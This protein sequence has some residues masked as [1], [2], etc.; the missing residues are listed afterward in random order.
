MDTDGDVI[1]VTSQDDLAECN[2]DLNNR[3]VLCNSVEAAR[4]ILMKA[5]NAASEALN[6]SQSLNQSFASINDAGAQSARGYGQLGAVGMGAYPQTELL[7][8]LHCQMPMY[9][10]YLTQRFHNVPLSGRFSV[11]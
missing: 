10:G 2:L 7:S 9:G 1:S 5:R 3:F 4:D 8:D 6:Q 11:G